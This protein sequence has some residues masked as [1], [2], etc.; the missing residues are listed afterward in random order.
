MN[1]GL[2]VTEG[3]SLARGALVVIEIAAGH[4]TLG[5]I[6]GLILTIMQ[7]YG[8][9]F[10]SNLSNMIQKIFR[11]I[12]A[13]VLLIMAYFGLTR[14]ISMPAIIVAIIA[15]G[16]RSMAY[17]SQVFR[18]GFKGVDPKQ[19]EAALSIGMSRFQAVRSIILPQVLRKVIGP[20][21][22]IFNMEVKDISL[23]YAIGVLEILKRGR[24]II[25][26]THGNSLLIYLSVAVFYFILARA[27]NMVLYRLE[28]MLR[29]PG[30]EGRGGS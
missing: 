27:G 2:L 14:I 3:P 13:L 11:S 29:V 7:V 23:A 12:P 30:F 19:M 9:K 15:L 17:Q 25:R 16:V 26:Y 20:W 1:L 10:A 8:G 21:S 5:F 28:E 6:G 24:Y 4:L 22:N 18:G